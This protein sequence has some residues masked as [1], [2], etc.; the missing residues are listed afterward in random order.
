MKN[1]KMFE[2]RKALGKTQE[3]LAKE[4][5]ITQSSYAMIEG[6]HRHPRKIV[7]K[8]LADYFSVTV[9]ELFFDEVNHV[10][11]LTA[12]GTEGGFNRSHQTARKSTNN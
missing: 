4:V 2:L 10:T 11:R 12:T 8:K 6:G 9:D 1:L 5:G 3:E 7:Q